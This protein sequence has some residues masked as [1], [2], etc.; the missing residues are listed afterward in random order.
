MVISLIVASKEPQM[1]NYCLRLSLP[2]RRHLR[3]FDVNDRRKV[4]RG[5]KDANLRRVSSKV[6]ETGAGDHRFYETKVGQLQREASRAVINS[7][8]TGTGIIP[9]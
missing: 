3:N 6:S 5:E 2:P 1:L 9:D 7:T 4:A 8:R